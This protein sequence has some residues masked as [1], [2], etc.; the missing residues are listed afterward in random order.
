MRDRNRLGKREWERLRDWRWGR[1]SEGEWVHE[2]REE[3]GK[4]GNI[5][6]GEEK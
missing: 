6:R 5:W 2:N 1:W 3:K 4:N